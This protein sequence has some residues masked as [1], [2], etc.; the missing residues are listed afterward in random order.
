MIQMVKT[1]SIR[2]GGENHMYRTNIFIKPFYPIYYCL[3]KIIFQMS[4]S[5]LPERYEIF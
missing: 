5:V 3:Q 1:N 4:K 2:R